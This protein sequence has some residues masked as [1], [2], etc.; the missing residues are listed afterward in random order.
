M[1]SATTMN[2]DASLTGASGVIGN[3]APAARHAAAP[4]NSAVKAL[5]SGERPGLRLGGTSRGGSAVTLA[6]FPVVGHLSRNLR[7]PFPAGRARRR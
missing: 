1:A 4:H 3:S 2:T 7:V 5:T 6:I